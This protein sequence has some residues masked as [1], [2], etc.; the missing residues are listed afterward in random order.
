MWV[1][2]GAGRWGDV[3]PGGDE[4]RKAGK[5]GGWE[6]IRQAGGRN[7]GIRDPVNTL[8]II[9]SDTKHN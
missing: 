8:A 6:K 2:G 9:E 7:T 4:L 5:F 3:Y 1:D